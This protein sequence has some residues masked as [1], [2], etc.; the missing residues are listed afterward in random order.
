ML[1]L[2]SPY[3]QVNHQG[4]LSYGGNQMWSEHPVIRKC[5]C[6]PVA[7]LDTV[8]YLENRGSSEPVPLSMYNVELRSLCRR[9]FPLVP[10]FGINGLVFV[11]GLNRLLRDRKLPYTAFWMLSGSKLW[12]RVEAMLWDDLPVILSV[13]PNFPAF[14]Q[15]NRL[16]FYVRSANGS[17]HRAAAT[18]GHFVTVTGMDENWVRISSWGRELY[19]NR[20]EYEEYTRQN[21]SYAFSNLVYL[22]WTDEK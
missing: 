20:S 9:Y 21:S 4:R 5:G 10:P 7:A 22:K 3:L 17:F 2:N 15:N 14:W 1:S 13:G 16:P 11:V 6:G 19:F 12:D 8:W 18:K